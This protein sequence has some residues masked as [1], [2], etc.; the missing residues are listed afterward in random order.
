M[1]IN[2][3]QIKLLERVAS[4]NDSSDLYTAERDAVRALLAELALYRQ[5]CDL[6]AIDA[7]CEKATPGPWSVVKDEAYGDEPE[8]DGGYVETKDMTENGE[9][10]DIL[11]LHDAEFCVAARTDLP[12]V[13]REARRLRA[14][15]ATLLHI[16]DAAPYPMSHDTDCVGGQ[17]VKD[18]ELCAWF[19]RLEIA[20][21]SAAK[22]KGN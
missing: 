6:D 7:R 5:P 12:A 19:R 10:Y 8:Y 13:S 15:N 1:S 14:E 16:I 9:G 18:C 4:G 17:C 21:A 2:E 11:R 3:D 20:A 22:A